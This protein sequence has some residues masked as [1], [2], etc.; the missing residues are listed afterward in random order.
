MAKEQKPEI[1]GSHDDV[2][3]AI[4]MSLALFTLFSTPL[5]ISA[6]TPAVFGQNPLFQVM[7]AL[8]TIGMV[9][10]VIFAASYAC[11]KDIDEMKKRQQQRQ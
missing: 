6:Y 11:S 7:A 8:T 5:I 3:T 4:V 10:A 9:F 2:T 1:S